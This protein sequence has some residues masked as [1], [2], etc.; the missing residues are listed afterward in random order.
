MGG[1]A[2]E[3]S[4]IETNQL[5]RDQDEQIR[6]L[7]SFPATTTVTRNSSARLINSST[8]ALVVSS[9]H[10]PRYRFGLASVPAVARPMPMARIK[11]QLTY[12]EDSLDLHRG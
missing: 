9:S 11:P 6:T 5:H 7:R 10:A 2:T 3:L 4:F 1:A 8:S 12:R